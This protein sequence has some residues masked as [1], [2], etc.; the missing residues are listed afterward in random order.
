MTSPQ[1]PQPPQS[2]QQKEMLA[3]VNLL[4]LINKM[5]LKIFS[6]KTRK[7]LIFLILNDTVQVVRYD[8][9]VLWSFE[10]DTPKIL[11]VSG[12]T[13][14]NQN[15]DLAKKWGRLISDLADPSKIQLFS[16]D[17]F[18]NEKRLW[19][20][21][22]SEEPKPA[23]LWMPI[24]TQEK[25]QLGLWLER[26]QGVSWTNQE[27]DILN[28][29]VQAYG[30]AWEKFSSMHS[31]SFLKKKRTIFGALALL[32]I[33]LSL[34]VSLRVVAPCEVVPKNPILITAP[35]EDIIAQVDV[36][37]GQHVKKGEVLFE[38]DKRIVAEN[39][40]AAEEQVNVAQL[41]LNRAKT[42][43]LKDDRSFA[44]IS[45]LAAKLKKE[46]INLELAKYHQS[47]LTVT[48]PEDG[49]VMLEDPEEWRGKPV[50]I[51][52]RVLMITNPDQ[53]KIRI[54]IPENDNVVLD[55]NQE[56]K[57]ILN[58]DPEKNRTALLSYIANASTV[59]EKHL[60]SF[61]AEAYWTTEPTDVKM[62]LKGTA[63]LY[64]QKV[65]V[66]YWIARKPWGY[67]RTLV[68]L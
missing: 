59:N 4:S 60:P 52:E 13:T 30:I 65:S 68:G 9:A 51:G 21:M 40:K 61:V 29:L 46:Q 19:V 18:S 26:W 22:E 66:F 25:R 34:R 56:I 45:V 24:I 7:A 57:I 10:G 43:A 62:G 6:T 17:S 35:L 2:P 49:V 23:I 33:L 39:L 14:V 67:L 5:N 32:L 37:P 63:I 1:P 38:Y 58:I 16:Q 28:F 54:W 42:L 53:T 64:G 20:E 15:S 50:H 36:K 48:S 3:A 12:Q 8:R 31:Y 27:A 47:Q 11:G 44:E 41:D 55:P